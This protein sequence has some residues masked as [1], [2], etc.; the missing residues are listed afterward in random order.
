MTSSSNY[1]VGDMEL[2]KEPKGVVVEGE[3]DKVVATGVSVVAF[4]N[5][6]NPKQKKGR[7]RK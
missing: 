4:G 2:L 5:T 1:F 6:L 3:G 7:T